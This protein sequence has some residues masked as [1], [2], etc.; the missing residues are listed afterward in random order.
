MHIDP[1]ERRW[2]YVIGV[3]IAAMLVAIFYT[4]LAQGIHPPSNV[5]SVDSAR[6]HMTEEFSEDNLGVHA[7]EDG[8]LTVVMVA[9]RYGFYP[10]NIELPSNTPVTFRMA[11]P[12]VIHG[13]HAPGTN[14]NVTI[15][16]GYVSQITTE[17]S[18]PGEYPLLCNEYCGLGHDHMWSRVTVVPPDQWQGP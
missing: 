8:A 2:F 11:T 15:I 10:L 18:E 14:F 16:P 3:M 12:D 7:G 13:V 17:F 1:L 6:L 5:E 9:A 4:G